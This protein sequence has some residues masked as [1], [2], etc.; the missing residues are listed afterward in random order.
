MT[1]LIFDANSLYARSWFAGQRISP[2]PREALRLA[3]NTI[4]LLLNPDTNK[5]STLFD[6]TLFAWD[7]NQNKAKNRDEK[8]AAYH[9]T[10][11]ALKTLLEY[12]L[13]TVNIDHPQAEGDDIVATAVYNT[14]PG[15][16]VYVV[17]GDKDLMQLQGGRCQYYSLNDKAVLSTAFILHKFHGILHPN[18]IALELA[19]IGDPVDSI[20]GIHGYGEVKCKKLFEALTPEMNLKVALDAILAQLPEAQ[21]E[22]FLAALDRTLLKCDVPGIP[23]PSPLSLR[24][25]AEIAWLKLGLNYYYQQVYDAYVTA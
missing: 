16:L 5:M 7:N 3:M 21:T 19:I 24:S 11:E 9:E 25:P 1:D 6:R 20:K 15:D 8:P 17:S 2:D 4:L 12:L 13:G 18:Q 14:K 23:E 10:K 22:E